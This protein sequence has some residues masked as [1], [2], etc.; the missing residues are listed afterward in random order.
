MVR[1]TEGGSV[2]RALLH[3]PG[4]SPAPLSALP[5]AEPPKAFPFSSFLLGYTAIKAAVFYSFG[6]L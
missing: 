3:Q 6:K 5:G 4:L 1:S 2:R